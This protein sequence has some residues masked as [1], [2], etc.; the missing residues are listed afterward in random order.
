MSDGETP[1]EA[2]APPS[3]LDRELHAFAA[4]RATLRGSHLPLPGDAP[5]GTFVHGFL[6]PFSLMLA[7]LRDR[8]LRGPYLQLVFVRGSVVAFFAIAVFLAGGS[9]GI[10]VHSSADG[11]STR[12]TDAPGFYLHIGDKHAE[13]EVSMLGQTLAT[14]AADGAQLPEP[15]KDALATV[16]A[17]ARPNWAWLIA[18]LS[19]LE[20]F[21]IF[22]SRRWDD[23]VSFHASWRLAAILP[24]DAEPNAPRLAFDFRRQY[25]KLK[26]RLTGC[27]AVAAGLPLLVPLRLIPIAGPWL[28][29]FGATLWG[30]YWLG[31]FSAGKSSH[32]WADAEQAQ[33][34]VPIRIFNQWTPRFFVFAPL[35][36]Y[37][38]LWKWVSRPF[39]PATTTFE[40]S[41][42]AFLGLG[43]AR[44]VLA[45]PGVYLFARPIIPVAAGRLCAEADPTARFSRTQLP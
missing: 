3:A 34:P 19:A 12:E 10:V 23:W 9:N 26:R 22:F 45:F 32:A 38:R 4:H 18:L 30:W 42:A 14:K 8:E 16:P 37:G 21:V 40:R 43:L 44:A 6:L 25:R 28:F 15:P 13:P 36:W 5:K 33:S 39:E 29:T 20:L 1:S 41:P 31:V 2:V 11:G 27:L 35:R 7:T 17:G 24:E